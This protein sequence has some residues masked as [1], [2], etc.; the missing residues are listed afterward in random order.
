MMNK[1][2]QGL[3]FHYSVIQFF[4]N[5][6][7]DLHTG[8]ESDQTQDTWEYQAQLWSN[9]SVGLWHFHAMK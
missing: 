5:M 2:I 3:E 8:C 4:N 1:P 7:Y 9:V 6:V